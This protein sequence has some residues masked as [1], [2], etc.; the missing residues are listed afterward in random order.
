METRTC[1]HA[2]DLTKWN[3]VTSQEP[4]GF[5]TL[6]EIK[7][8]K[9]IKGITATEGG[10]ALN[11]TADLKK[12]KNPKTSLSCICETLATGCWPFY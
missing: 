1:A 11:S 9:K 6:W 4:E 7:D 8:E 10:T 12:K 2:D 5:F 3:R